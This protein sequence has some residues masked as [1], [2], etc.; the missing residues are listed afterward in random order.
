MNPANIIASKT[1]KF[2]QVIASLYNKLQ[3]FVSQTM[4]YPCLLI[5]TSPHPP[6][7]G[8]H[9]IGVIDPYT[10]VTFDVV[11]CM[12]VRECLMVSKQWRFQQQEQGYHNVKDSK[13]R[14][15]YL[16]ITGICGGPHG[17]H[18]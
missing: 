10:T 17:G 14:L 13:C 11:R 16:G 3:Q 7:K 15:M 5:A 6:T 18:I 1:S 8:Q 12:F 4:L 9:H 2:L